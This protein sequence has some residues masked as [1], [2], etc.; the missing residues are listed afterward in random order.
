M[1]DFIN[2]TYFF[3]VGSWKIVYQHLN[4][5]YRRGGGIGAGVG[6]AIELGFGYTFVFI[7]LLLIALGVAIIK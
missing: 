4:G 1:N 3:T 2:V 6:G 7:Q 5:T